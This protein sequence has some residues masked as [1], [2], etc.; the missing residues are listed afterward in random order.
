MVL[1]LKIAT[2]WDIRLKLELFNLRDVTELRGW[3][4]STRR[5]FFTQLVP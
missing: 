3:D 1:A 5:N 4:N 2:I